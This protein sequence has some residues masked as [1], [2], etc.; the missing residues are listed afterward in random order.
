VAG[1]AGA[2]P[3]SG[4]LAGAGREQRDHLGRSDGRSRDGRQSRRGRLQLL[5]L[6]QLQGWHAHASL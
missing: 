3:P 1:E 4:R 5:P 2:R 6:L